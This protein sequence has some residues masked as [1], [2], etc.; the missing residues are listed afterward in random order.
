MWASSKS[1]GTKIESD[2]SKKY[3]N[4]GISA[5]YPK[6][7]HQCL[8]EAWETGKTPSGYDEFNNEWGKTYAYYTP[9]IING[10]KLGIIGVEIDISNIDREIFKAT[11][12][13][14]GTICSVLIFFMLLLLLIIRS[15][16][17]RKLI[18]M[19]QM[20]EEYSQTKNPKVA[21]KLSLE[22]T[23]TD[24]ISVIMKKFADMIY[25]LDQYMDSLTKTQQHLHDTQQRA[26]E[27][28]LLAI[29]DPLTGIRNKTGYD[30]EVENIERE[31]SGGMNEIGVA[32]VDLNFLKKLN[33]NYGHD[34]GNVAIKTLSKIICNV[35]SHS[36]VFRI[37]G[38][39]FVVILKGHDL[40]HIDEL[41]TQFKEQLKEHQTNPYYAYWERV[42][43]AIGYAIYNPKQDSGYESLFKRADAEMYKAKKTM[44]AMRGE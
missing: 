15:N 19:Q 17:I 22:I 11:M 36:P 25:Q 21:E 7:S 35:F 23:N 5:K 1:Y 37:G 33:D 41:D 38:D 4:L 30:K 31:L 24:E 27:M 16:Y 32:M 9:L 12:R 2:F 43:A 18:V 3:I 34:K 28:S 29:K 44:K 6:E 26:M 42:S 39:E 13:H 8:W 10:Q 14:M 40:E 20:I